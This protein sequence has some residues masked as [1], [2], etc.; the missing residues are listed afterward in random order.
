MGPKLRTVINYV[1]ARE[2]LDNESLVA[3]H[4][5]YLHTFQHI[6]LNRLNSLDVSLTLPTV[7][8]SKRIVLDG[9]LHEPEDDDLVSILFDELKMLLIKVFINQ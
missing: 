2:K 9:G 4:G 1:D 3:I 5:M 7:A 6:E 8:F